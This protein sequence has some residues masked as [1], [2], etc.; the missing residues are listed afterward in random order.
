MNTVDRPT[1]QD[2]WLQQAANQINILQSMVECEVSGDAR[3]AFFLR[4]VEDAVWCAMKSARPGEA[5]MVR[6]AWRDRMNNHIRQAEVEFQSL[7][8]V[9]SLDD[10][11]V[12]WKKL[13]AV[14][15]AVD[16]YLEHAL[17]STHGFDARNIDDLKESLSIVK[18]LISPP[19][20]S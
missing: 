13:R 10:L 2:G 11:A 7:G 18:Q 1:R 15:Y 3:R 12:I 8:V 9:W 4:D 20:K 17:E 16:G 14:D 6:V 19:E 5:H